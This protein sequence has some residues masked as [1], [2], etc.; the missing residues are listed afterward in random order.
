[1]RFANSGTEAVASA[2]RLA[3]AFTGRQNII[4]FEGHY[5]GWS[6]AVF[7]QYHAPLEALSEDPLRPAIPG[8]AGMAGAPANAYVVS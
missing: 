6:D 8:T 2:I 4:L 7:H 3:R 5:H 1:L